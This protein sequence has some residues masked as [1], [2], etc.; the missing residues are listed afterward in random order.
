LRERE[1]EREREGNNV[2]KLEKVR[3]KR[4]EVKTKSDTEINEKIIC[5]DR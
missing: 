2:R 1:R 4:E 3:K 5:I